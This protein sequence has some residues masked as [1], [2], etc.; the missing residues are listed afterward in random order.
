MALLNTPPS[1][2]PRI[3]TANGKSEAIISGPCW[4]KKP[5]GTEAASLELQ[6]TEMGNWRVVLSLEWTLVCLNLCPDTTM[7]GVYSVGPLMN[8]SRTEQE[9]ESIHLRLRALFWNQYLSHTKH[10][11][12]KYAHQPLSLSPSLSLSRTTILATVI[13]MDCRV[14]CT[15]AVCEGRIF[16]SLYNAQ[17]VSTSSVDGL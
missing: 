4:T 8:C 1:P 15:E 13:M 3:L 5:M 16:I 17:S 7:Y 12:I 2:K 6:E 14:A 9:F 11:R 10:R